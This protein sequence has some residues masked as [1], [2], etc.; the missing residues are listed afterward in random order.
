MDR[1]EVQVEDDIEWNKLTYVWHGDKE[2]VL[3]L[4]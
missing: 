3:V 4:S 1:F 2:W